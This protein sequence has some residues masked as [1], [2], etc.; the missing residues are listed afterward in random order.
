MKILLVV[1]PYRTTDVLVAKLYPMPL[2]A[3]QL[4]AVLRAAGHEVAVRDFLTPAQQHKAEAPASFAG[5]HAPPY[6]H[7]GAKLEDCK[8]WLEAQA[9]Q[10]DAVGL[11]AGQCNLYETAAALGQ[12]VHELG[13]PLVVGGSYVTTATAQAVERFAADVAVVGEGEGVVVQA[14]EQAVAGWRG[15]IQGEP[16]ADLNAL[17]L[18]AWDLVRLEDYPKAESKLRGVLSVS[19]GCPHACGFCSV[20]TVHG[21]RHRREAPERVRE[22]LLQLYRAG[23]RYVC[24][25]DDNLFISAKATRELLDVIAGLRT[26]EPGFGKVQF[27]VEEGIEVR[28]AAEPGL[29]R[30]IAA[31]GFDGVALGVETLSAARLSEQAKPY[32]PEQLERAVAEC[33]AAEIVPR[34]FYI[35]GLPGDTLASVAHDLVAF[36]KLGMAARPNNLKLYPG[37]D[38]TRRFLEHGWI[39]ADYDWRL[40]SFYTPTGAG[41]EYATIRQL[42]TELGAIGFAAEVFGVRVFADTLEAALLAINA[43]RG[44]QARLEGEVLVL[45]GNMFRP[46]PYRHLLE[47]LQLAAG[48][49]GADAQLAGKNR[50]ECRRLPAPRTEVQA[51]VVAALRGTELQLVVTTTPEPPRPPAAPAQLVEPTWVVGDSLKV[52][53]QPGEPVDLVFTCHPSGTMVHTARGLVPIEYV[54]PGDLVTTH[55]GRE[56]AVTELLAFG[57]TGAL[58]RIRRDYGPELEATSDHPI[59]IE[60]NG[61][62]RWTH[63]CEVQPGDY[64]LEPVPILTGHLEKKVVWTWDRP[65]RT[66]RRGIEASG[67]HSVFATSAL[68]RLLGYYLAEGSC[69]KGSVQFAFHEAEREYQ[70]DVI[71]SFGEV[72]HG[73]AVLRPPVTGS[74]VRTVG[75]NGVIAVSFFGENGG[76]GAANKRFPSWV[77]N[78]GE[79]LLAELVR[80]CWRGDGWSEACGRLGFSSVSRQLVDDMR[81]ALLCW[82][83]VASM[84]ERDRGTTNYGKARRSWCLIVRGM[85]AERL[86][87]LLGD[88]YLPASRRRPGRG[89]FVAA[90]L[91]HYRVRANTSR[92]VDDFP[93]YNLEVEED[94][95]Y[96]ANGVSSHNCPPYADLEVYSDD[97]ADISSMDYPAFSAAYREIVRLALARLRPDRFA[98][99]VISDI[100]GAGGFYRGLPALTV[101]AFE[102]AGAKLYNEAVLVT[103]VGSLPIRAGKIFEA[104]RKLGRGHQEVLVFVK[105]DARRATEALGA[106][107]FGEL[108]APEA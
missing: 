100:R 48:A 10:Y 17:P 20:H 106:C 5:R 45:E 15:V 77:W 102:A 89:P 40:S 92:P 18:P 3:L 46:T 83:I 66:S 96:L 65:A 68:M 28:L 37:T 91:C 36:G 107:E 104:S 61:E 64:L 72:F 21:R 94:H 47:L 38:C 53:A 71:D 74:R 50:V 73:R 39:A 30:E 55:L 76:R 82:G 95:S 32:K 11:M 75:C 101:E 12:H 93:V 6:L 16:V 69:S 31:A 13:R 23:A 62:R 108:P 9:E 22:K 26:D 67:D 84:R 105:G 86:A 80:C 99:V 58:H 8:T 56:R 33:Q 27:Y 51:A 43:T 35:V 88:A 24:F 41:L 87:T 78:C 98:V 14:F 2:A 1:P 103:A 49:E 59:L 81:R 63:A 52:L 29:M 34:A 57:Y 19:R 90:G 44:Y 79:N 54:V 42:K 25:L 4:A 60:R 70:D 7:F 85:H 97:P